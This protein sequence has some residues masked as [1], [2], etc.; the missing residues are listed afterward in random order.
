MRKLEIGHK[1]L[2]YITHIYNESLFL[3]EERNYRENLMVIL[4]NTYQNCKTNI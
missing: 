1:S 2:Q 4:K 3:F